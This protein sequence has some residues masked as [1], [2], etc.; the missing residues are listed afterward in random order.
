M[1]KI[2]LANN[3]VRGTGHHADLL[4]F[5]QKDSIEPITR[6]H[7]SYEGYNETPLVRLEELSKV[8]GVKD[9]YVK[10]ESKRFGLNAFKVL[11]GLY[12][13][14]RYLSEKADIPLEELTFERLNS[15][16]LK[17]KV[18]N[19]VF[20][21]ATDGN[22]GRGVAWAAKKLGFHAVIYMPKGSSLRR[23]KHI[24][25]TGAEGF[26]TEWNYDDTVRY[27]AEQAEKNNWVVVQDTAWEGYEKIPEW[28]MQG[29]SMIGAELEEQ[30]KEQRP[31]HLFLQA[32][33]GSFAA[34]VLGYM[35]LLYGEE[36]PKTYIV[37]P[38]VADCYYQSFKANSSHAVNVGGAMQ[39]IMAG[40]ACG[41]PNE[42]AWNII[43][44]YAH[45]GFSCDDWIAELGMRVLGNPLGEDDRVISGESGAAPVGLVYDLMTAEDSIGI[46]KE[47]GLDEKSVILVIS[48]EGDT[49]PNHYRK[50]VWGHITSEVGVGQI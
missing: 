48:T 13:I 15:K 50:V 40:L 30:L 42:T 24:T 45:G 8:I 44:E 14:G 46:A 6:F 1:K 32:G 5:L 28:I 16:E 41:E 23:L 34:A 35:A 49:D 12:A 17:K 19:V 7:K 36:L 31:T 25:D 47:I 2:K 3:T 33:V 22:H 18:G 4:N 27:V 26:I 21:S 10:D 29:Y 43:S 9:I 37:E 11:G 38:D 39:T 20:A